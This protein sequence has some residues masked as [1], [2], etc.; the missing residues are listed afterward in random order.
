[1]IEPQCDRFLSALDKRYNAKPMGYYK[2]ERNAIEA[3][4][5]GVFGSKKREQ[6]EN[7]METL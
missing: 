5:H 4:Q 7:Q 2:I 1:L 3:F 6:K